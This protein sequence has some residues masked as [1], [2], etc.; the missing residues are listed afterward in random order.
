MPENIPL[1]RFNYKISR[2]ISCPY[3]GCLLIS[4]WS[5]VKQLSFDTVFLF[6]KE[7]WRDI[8]VMHRFKL[9]HILCAQS[10]KRVVRQ[11]TAW[12]EKEGR[13]KV[14]QKQDNLSMTEQDFHQRFLKN[15]W[16][17]HVNQVNQAPSQ[18]KPYTR[19]HNFSQVWMK[20]WLED[21]K[22]ICM[23]HWIPEG[24]E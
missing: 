20:I 3:G 14:T 6:S 12:K 17:A 15:W 2:Q 21:R 4:Q 9:K 10:L 23:F 5:W 11:S 1:K 22:K 24:L 13:K 16:L 19:T 18:M 7:T 8:D